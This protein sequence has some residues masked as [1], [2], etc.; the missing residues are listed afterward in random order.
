MAD[1]VRDVI[2]DR[3][4]R[5]VWSLGKSAITRDHEIDDP[6]VREVKKAYL[7]LGYAALEEIEQL[8][9]TI[10]HTVTVTLKGTAD[11]R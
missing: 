3:I 5:R 2:A 10:P 8:G 7:D 11:G 6:Q 4:A 9:I 1:S